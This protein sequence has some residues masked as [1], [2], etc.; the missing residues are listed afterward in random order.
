[1]MIKQKRVAFMGIYHIHCITECALF[2][3]R[4]LLKSLLFIHTPQKNRVTLVKLSER[5][6]GKQNKKPGTTDVL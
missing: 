1:M 6:G 5:F 2:L 4:L 3:P